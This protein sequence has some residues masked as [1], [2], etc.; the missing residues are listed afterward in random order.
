MTTITAPLAVTHTPNLVRT[1]RV[2]GAWYL[3]L[4]IT[5]LLG[6]V[7]VRAQIY[8]M[9]SAEATYSNLVEKAGLAQLGFVLELAVLVA[10]ALVAVW[11]YKLYREAS[12]VAAIAIMV[13]G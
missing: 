3:A 7:V 10:Q 5:G 6:F 12:H 11:F 9:D 13:F 2:T 4:A 1:A 8:D